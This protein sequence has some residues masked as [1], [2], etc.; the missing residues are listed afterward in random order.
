MLRYKYKI[1]S[2]PTKSAISVVMTNVE[3]CEIYK[4]LDKCSKLAHRK[5]SQITFVKT[6]RTFAKKQFVVDSV[7]IKVIQCSEWTQNSRFKVL[8]FLPGTNQL[9]LTSS[10]T[11][12]NITSIFL[13]AANMSIKYD[14]HDWNISIIWII[15]E[16]FKWNY[17]IFVHM[18]TYLCT[19]KIILVL[20]T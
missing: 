20:L 9:C 16:R 14:S 11:V 17:K 3:F 13:K 4:T 19:L 10:W 6:W 5:K 2:K 8:V 7:M 15:R 18:Q 12:D 1:D